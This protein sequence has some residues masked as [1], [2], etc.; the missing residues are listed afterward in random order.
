[1][2]TKPIPAV[3]NNI[4]DLDLSA[5]SKKTFRINNDDSRMFELNTS[6][7][8]IIKRIHDYYPKLVAL[9]EKTSTI[10]SDVDFD[11]DASEAESVQKLGVVADRL[12]E[13]DTEM[14]QILDE[15]FNA[16]VSAACA[17][18]GSM[19]DPFNGSFRFEYIINTLIS[20]YESNLQA[21]YKRME[22]QVS[23]HT[24]KYKKKV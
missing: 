24:S 11:D 9:Q 12:S 6:D 19:Y 3:A 15:I 8:N 7:M 23:K 21:E 2:P 4:I 16:P 18:D 1:M 17:P 20:Q 14:R 13:I 10:T 5:T 22:K